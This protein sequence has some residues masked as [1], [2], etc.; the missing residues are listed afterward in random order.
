MPTVLTYFSVFI[1]FFATFIILPY[2]IK[3]AKEHNLLLTDV[4]KTDQ[5]Q[6]PGLGGLIVVFGIVMGVMAYV[7][8]HTFYYDD[9]KNALVLF[10]AT[11]SILLSA[12]I[13][14]VDDLLGRK[15]G[16]RQYQKPILTLFVALPVMV[17]N[18]GTAII[19][20]PFIGQ[21]NLGILFPLIFIPAGIVGASN[22]FNMLAGMNGLEAG[23]G[24]ILTATIGYISFTNNSIPAAIL[25]ACVFFAVLAFWLYNKYPAKIL[26][27]NT[28]TYSIGTSIAL[29]AII[30]NI[31]K[32]A[33]ILF[34]PY[35]IEFLLKLR[36][37]MQKET[38]VNVRPD[39]SL[40]H[41]YRK[42]YATPHVVMSL[43]QKCRIKP[44]EWAVVF[45]IHF[46]T[47]MLALIVLWMYF[48]GR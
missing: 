43:L 46:I 5:R 47:A 38:L 25:A 14:L 23:M 34:L 45:I 24:L 37:F 2:W 18:A 4:H 40:V 21:T 11:S 30:G 17:I 26:C 33:L 28:F 15:I 39:G 12:L 35:Y 10:A 20:L 19:T 22:A 13:G 7:A 9:K 41:R 44:R 31:E 27:G 1:S 3:R 42:W 6:I 16:L 8:L 48:F 32:Y 36:G 29:I